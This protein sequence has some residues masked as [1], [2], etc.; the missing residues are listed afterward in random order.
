[1]MKRDAEYS[2]FSRKLVKDT[3]AKAEHKPY[4]TTTSGMSGH[5]A[6]MLWWNDKDLIG[7]L[8]FWEPLETGLGRYETQE[9]A[10]AEGRIWAEAEG[11]EFR[12]GEL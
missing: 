12:E 2:A 10:A 11:V 3:I 1:M 7:G 8:G 9:Q 4:V 6:V 5:F